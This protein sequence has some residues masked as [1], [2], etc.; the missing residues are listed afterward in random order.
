MANCN[1]TC[2]TCEAWSDPESIRTRFT[3]WTDA[4]SGVDACW[5]W[6]GSIGSNGY[7]RMNIGRVP[8]Y[9]HRVS[10]M[11]DGREI[12]DGLQVDHLCSTPACVN[13]KHLE[14]VTQTE[15][16]RRRVTRSPG[17]SGT[18]GV[19][20]HKAK[21]RWRVKIA[22]RFVGHFKELSD[23]QSAAEAALSTAQHSDR[24]ANCP[25]PYCDVE[26]VVHHG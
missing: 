26:A 20:W 21:R 23:A 18:L 13:P 22:G 6:T 25:C 2:H 15:N 17:P 3:K 9:A 11:L 7:G 10:V 16:I 19:T 8:E 4:S 12:A 14:V 5:L 1:H 24:V